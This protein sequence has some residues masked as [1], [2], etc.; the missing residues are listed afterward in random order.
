MKFP[1]AIVDESVALF[2]L[3]NRGMHRLDDFIYRPVG[4]PHLFKALEHPLLHIGKF[5]SSNFF[6]F[7]ES[8][9]LESFD[10]D[11]F[12][13]LL[14]VRTFRISFNILSLS[15]A[16]SKFSNSSRFTSSR[17]LHYRNNADFIP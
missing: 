11:S 2:D 5:E 3:V 1:G 17:A 6:A 9:D 4:K 10:V 16:S 13:C 12:L 8:P 14:R 15:A 7:S